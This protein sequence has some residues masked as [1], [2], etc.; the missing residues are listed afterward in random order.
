MRLPATYLPV[1]SA[2]AS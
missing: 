2:A 1:C